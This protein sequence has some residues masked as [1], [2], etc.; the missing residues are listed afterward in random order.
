MKV[1]NFLQGTMLVEAGELHALNDTPTTKKSEGDNKILLLGTN[2]MQ[3]QETFS[4]KALVLSQNFC[5][6]RTTFFREP[7]CIS[8]EC[9]TLHDNGIWLP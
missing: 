8:F 4:F 6:L 5:C 2:V 7:N 1:L 9:P 3:K